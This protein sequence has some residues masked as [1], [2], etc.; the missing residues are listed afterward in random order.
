MGAVE[1]S[2]YCLQC[3]KG[4]TIWRNS[5]LKDKTQPRTEG[6]DPYTGQSMTLD[7]GVNEHRQKNILQGN[8]EKSEKPYVEQTTLTLYLELNTVSNL[9]D[10]APTLRCIFIKETQKENKYIYSQFEYTANH[11][12]L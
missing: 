8:K 11:P 3:D 6:L 5:L 9:E 1:N 12:Y 4:K 10:A 2:P 7:A